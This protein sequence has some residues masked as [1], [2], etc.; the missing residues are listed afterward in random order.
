MSLRRAWDFGFIHDHALRKASER[1]TQMKKAVG[2]GSSPIVAYLAAH[3]H[4]VVACESTIS[5]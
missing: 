5:I 4:N 3:S 1:A 2:L